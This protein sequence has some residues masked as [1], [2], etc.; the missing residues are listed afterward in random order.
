MALFFV[1]QD[2]T[3]MKVDAIVNA[4]NT[5]LQQGGGVCGAIFAAAG[6]AELTAECRKIGHCAT[7][8]AV[9]T[10]G[11]H[12]LARYVIHT[13]G[14]VWRGGFAQE[15]ELLK[16]CYR[17]SLELAAKHDCA[18][19]AFPLISSGIYGYPKA[20]ALRVAIDTI[21]TFL[22]AHEM[23]V[24][25]VIFGRFSL[26]PGK[27]ITGPLEEFL[28]E[29]EEYLPKMAARGRQMNAS[30]ALREKPAA[31][32]VKASKPCPVAGDRPAGKG[33]IAGSAWADALSV[34]SDQE[35]IP[36]W[37]AYDALPSIQVPPLEKTFAQTV[38]EII[39]ARGLQDVEVYKRA[40][41]DRKVFS[42][43]RTHSDYQPSRSTAISLA[44]G[45]KLGVEEAYELLEKAGYTLSNA[46][47]AD[48]I[49]KYFL[50]KGCYDIITLNET[51]LY[52]G[53]KPFGPA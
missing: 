19:I 22:E 39:A 37:I 8:Q 21:R 42:K 14:P 44:L 27:D 30:Y 2:I 25:L 23:T 18:S 40:N 47:K 29:N 33:D 4:A 11:C 52:Y 1:E 15:E 46:S 3:T 16:G 38:L 43:L 48:L 51:L 26:V 12:L 10:S 7:G 41:L 35:E 24:Y 13:P 31:R 28:Q 32:D 53:E 6:A 34:Q 49:V 9:L 45:L 20:E 5:E 36:P 17:N 50:A